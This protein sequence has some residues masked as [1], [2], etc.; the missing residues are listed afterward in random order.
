MSLKT[1]IADLEECKMIKRIITALVIIACVIPPLWLGGYFLDALISIVI[2]VGGFE[3]VNLLPSRKFLST[4]MLFVSF[5]ITAALI[6]VPDKYSFAGF[7]L[8][9]LTILAFPIFTKQFTSEDAFFVIAII[10][11]LYMISMSFTYIYDYNHLYIWYILLATYGCDTGAYF[12]GSLFGKTKLLP[13][14]S[15]K[16]TV[17][18]AVGGW[19]V[20]A[21]LSFLFAMFVIKDMN[22]LLMILGCLWLPIISQI[23]DLSFSSIKRHF[24][25]KD[26]SN[27]FPGHG[28]FMDRIDSLVFN[29]IAFYAVMVMIL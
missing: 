3:L 17:E 23:G 13:T 12:V 9:V 16:K 22:M 25:I 2:I 21:G 26:F 29:L 10:C 5:L 24:N 18:G 1:V 15:P 14:I 27:I 20:G 11:I 6:V 19:A 8:L 4:P 28:G 7:A